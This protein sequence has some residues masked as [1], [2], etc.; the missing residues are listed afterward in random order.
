MRFEVSPRAPR[1]AGPY[2]HAVA[3]GGFVYTAGFGPQDP[4]TGEVAEDI[5]AQTR[6]VLE[7]LRVALRSVDSDLHAVVKTTCHLRHPERDFAE[8]NT[9]YREFFDEPYPVRTTVGSE[10]PGI[11]VE[12]DAVAVSGDT[13]ETD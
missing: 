3:V 5:V 1:P 6:Q 11:L 10:L 13:A 2:S 7:N 12:I 8:F 4:E 9:A